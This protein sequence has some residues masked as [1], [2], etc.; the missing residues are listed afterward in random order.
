MP[1]GLASPENRGK[2]VGYPSGMIAHVA[3]DRLLS[4]AV[5]PGAEVLANEGAIEAFKERKRKEAEQKAA[6]ERAN[7]VSGTRVVGKLDLGEATE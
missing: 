4:S 1:V 3:E 5:V 6:E 7:A 2:F